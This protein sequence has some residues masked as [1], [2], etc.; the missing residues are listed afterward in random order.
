MPESDLAVMVAKLVQRLL[1]LASEDHELRSHVR[2]LALQV[3]AAIEQVEAPAE[4]TPSVAAQTADEK[5]TPAIAAMSPPRR[6]APS[7]EI[8]EGMQAAV[9]SMTS[10]VPVPP[11]VSA[12]GPV[13]QEVT[14]SD[15]P[16]I[17]ERCRVK[18][19]GARWAAKRRQRLAEGADYQLEIEPLDREIIEK[20]KKLPDC[21]LWTNHPSGP[22]P[23]D[24][25]LLDDLAGCFETTADA[26]ALVRSLLVE[27]EREG[28]EFEQAL[29]LLAEAQS[30]LRVAVNLVGYK[31]DKDQLCTY[32]WLR[33]TCRRDQVYIK[34][35]MQLTDQANPKEWSS[36][37]DRIQDLDARA[38]DR[39]QRRKQHESALKKA[40]YHAKRLLSGDKQDHARDWGIVIETVDYLVQGG[41][42][43][44]SIDLRDVLLPVVEEM[45]DVDLPSN[46]RL[47]MREID[48]F[49]AER[50][51]P[52]PKEQRVEA[53]EKVK[54]VAKWLTGK[55]LVLIGGVPRPHAREALK[56]AFGLKEVDWVETQDH[57]SVAR[58]ESHVA[59]PEVAVVL[60]AI[61]W[62][63][64]SFADVKQFCDRHGK[65][66]VRLPA[67]YNPNQVAAQIAQQCGERLEACSSSLP[68]V[69][70]PSGG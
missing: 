2:A 61:R 40:R 57:D 58:F 43:P 49:L 34:R 10:A 45:P 12:P 56:R 24:L 48:R 42:Q 41:T 37:G 68:K 62:S 46:F 53:T 66:L 27:S 21:F 52:Q 6:V 65:P 22:S 33:S 69:P 38:Q 20:A 31:Q 44:S 14:D 32:Q 26:I 11:S 8:L 9:Q 50:P 47:V 19:E 23:S 59:R 17:E 39:Q 54:Q 13:S 30:A 36:L 7:P 63:S 55:T 3:L 16:L 15:L 1:V 51:T 64:H 25:S 67:G 60:L 29:E 28:T 35:Y 18:A 5:A 70:I 4:G